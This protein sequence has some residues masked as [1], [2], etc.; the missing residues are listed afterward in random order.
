MEKDDDI[1]DPKTLKNSFQLFLGMKYGKNYLKQT[2]TF[3]I[4]RVSVFDGVTMQIVLLDTYKITYFVKWVCS[5]CT[6][7]VFQGL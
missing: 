6:I 2:L 7:A 5:Y 4:L 3:E 1:V